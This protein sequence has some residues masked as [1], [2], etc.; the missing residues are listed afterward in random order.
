MNDLEQV[1]LELRRVDLEIKV[2]GCE[3]VSEVQEDV[4]S[5]VIFVDWKKK[6]AGSIWEGL[7]FKY[8]N[9]I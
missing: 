3:M 5:M 7:F 8:R 2:L 1:Q 6:E 4:G 9:G